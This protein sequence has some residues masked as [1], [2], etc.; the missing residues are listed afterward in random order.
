M[1]ETYII[2]L[3]VEAS[4]PLEHCMEHCIA[5]W[6]IA[7]FLLLHPLKDLLEDAVHEYC[8]IR[9]KTLCT[10]GRKLKWCDQN[11]RSK[12]SPWALDFVLGIQEAYKWE[13]RYL[14]EVLMEFMWAGKWWTL[15]P[16]VVPA[17]LNQLKNTPDF[18]NDLL[19]QF[20]ARP[21]IT[22]AVW[23]PCYFAGSLSNRNNTCLLC[24]KDLI[25]GRKDEP[26]VAGQIRNPFV[27]DSANRD[28]IGW[29][30]DCGNLG[31]I[32]WR[33]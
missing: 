17:L 7:D 6:H 26:G 5:L 22:N 1:A 9:M 13:A 4:I 21:W 27:Q 15:G 25:L 19:G 32:P 20:A 8:D 16:R 23:A 3:D 14:K 30:K 33:K 11:D 31:K 28:P 12:L 29:C 2:G 18:M 10:I 24:H